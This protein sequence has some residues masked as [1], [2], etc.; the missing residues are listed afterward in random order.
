MLLQVY[1]NVDP[2]KY[3]HETNKIYGWLFL[4][5]KN[6]SLLQ[7]LYVRI[8]ETLPSFIKKLYQSSYQA[9]SQGFFKACEILWNKGIL[10]NIINITSRKIFHREN[11]RSFCPGCSKS[12]SLN[13][14][15]NRLMRIIGQQNQSTFY[16]IEK[17]SPISYFLQ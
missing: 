10:I 4:K 9:C 1:F 5:P 8:S 6:F 7:S 17:S 11:L 13:A 16:I 12:C 15:I 14:K 2:F 3:F